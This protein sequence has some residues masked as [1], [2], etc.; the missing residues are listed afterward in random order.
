MQIPVLLLAA[1]VLAIAT[2]VPARADLNDKQQGRLYEACLAKVD[3]A[4]ET[5]GFQRENFCRCVVRAWSWQP[6]ADEVFTKLIAS[7]EAKRTLSRDVVEEMVTLETDI[8]A[9]GECASAGGS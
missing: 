6:I 9:W 4:T 1:L 3:R 8:Q 2:A 5:K 7:Y